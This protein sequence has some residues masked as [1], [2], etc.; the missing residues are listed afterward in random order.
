MSALGQKPDIEVCRCPLYPQK[1][2]SIEPVAMSAL[3]QKETFCVAVE[4]PVSLQ[5][6]LASISIRTAAPGGV[7]AKIRSPRASANPSQIRSG[8]LK[9]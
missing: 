5:F 3:C 6:G 2:T 9:V 4:F 8:I 7:G 1:R